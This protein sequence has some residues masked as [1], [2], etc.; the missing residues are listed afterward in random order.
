MRE[1][2][3]TTHVYTADDETDPAGTHV[4]TA[5]DE[6]GRS[7]DSRIHRSTADEMRGRS[8]ARGASREHGHT[9]RRTHARTCARANV[10]PAG[11]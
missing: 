7:N 9:G 2:P 4:S 11:P 10:G 3:A 1:G 6:I 5:G 8:V